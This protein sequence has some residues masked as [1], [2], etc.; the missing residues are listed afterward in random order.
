MKRSV[1]LLFLLFLLTPFSSQAQVTV[2]IPG[3]NVVPDSLMQIWHLGKD[4]MRRIK[5]IEEDYS[6]ERDEVWSTPD[7]DDQEKTRRLM[8]LG[9]ARMGEIKGV[10][11]TTSFDLWQKAISAAT[12]PKAVD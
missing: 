4:Q 5:V 1:G 11:G 10:L 8:K 7:V 6:T 2:D 12:T 9:E 3:W